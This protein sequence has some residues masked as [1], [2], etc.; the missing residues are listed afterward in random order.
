MFLSVI[1]KEKIKKETIYAGQRK[2]EAKLNRM[3]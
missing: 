3:V 2:T 1:I